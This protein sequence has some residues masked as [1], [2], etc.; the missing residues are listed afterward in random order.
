MNRAQLVALADICDSV[1]YGYTASANEQ[2]VGPRFLRITDIVPDLIA[3]DSV[4]FCEIDDSSKE[5]FALDVGDIVVARTGATV[6]YAKLIRNSVDAVFASY[7]VRFR[8]D[9]KKADPG[10][11][12]RIVESTIY[13]NF[14]KSQVGGAAQPN[15]NAQ[16]LGC[17]QFLLPL[18][19]EQERIAEILSAYDDLIEN[20]RRRMRLLEE[21]ARQL[22]QEWFVRLRFPGHEHTHIIDGVPEGWERTSFEAA[23]VLQRGF[24]LPIQD[25]EDGDVP[26]YG[27]TGINGFH[28]KSKVLGPGVVTGRSG[29]L[30]EVHYIPNDFWPLNTFLWVKEYKRVTPLFSLFLMREMDLKQYN[31]GASVPTLDRK[32]VHRVAILFP[33][34]NLLL[35]FDEFVTPLFDQIG[36]L[37]LQNQKL[38]TARDLLL[39]RLMNGKITV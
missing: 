25:R 15:A 26:I 27:S 32:A 36:N 34:K 9:R 3:W 12:G 6:G 18:R 10:F 4:P 22:Y 24:D 35:A 13:K 33:A 38:R 1:R 16:V 11:V 5:R 39:P 21:S 8:V 31:G 2:E 23:L 37:T 7:L 30:G 28:N 29:T 20:N 19:R 14:I 17:F